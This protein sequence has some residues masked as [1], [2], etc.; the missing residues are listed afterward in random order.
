MSS[1]AFRFVTIRPPQHVAGANAPTPVVDL[2]E[3]T[4]SP[5]TASLRKLR[6]TG[7]RGD[8]LAVAAKFRSSGGFASS[9]A[10]LD[11]T[12]SSF[13]AKVQTLGAAA[14][15]TDAQRAFP[16]L[17]STTPSAY[18]ATPPYTQSVSRVTDSLLVAAMVACVSPN[19]RLLLGRA[20][21]A[22]WLIRRMAQQD[23]ISWRDFNAAPLALAAGIFPLP[24][25]GVD[26][27]AQQKV[28]SDAN[29]AALAARRKRLAQLASSLA[30]SR[31]AI[32]ELLKSLTRADSKSATS[33]ASNASAAAASSKQPGIA[34]P[35]AN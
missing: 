19:V 35:D 8:L 18:V 25:A 17:F 33:V 16:E 10:S 27:K 15:W 11:K 31:R 28:Q 1:D 14:F 4:P 3:Q 23:E 20:A 13:V 6:P 26:V 24:V 32:D 22:L 9:L 30:A 2:G 21:R 7:T 12:L 29:A 5:L 34:L